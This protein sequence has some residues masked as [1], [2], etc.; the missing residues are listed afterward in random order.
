MQDR[1]RRYALLDL[2]FSKVTRDNR[3]AKNYTHSAENLTI[4]H[5]G[6]HVLNCTCRNESMNMGE[7]EGQ[8]VVESLGRGGFCS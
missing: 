1:G 2:T 7:G 6:E 5:W 8:E 3:L 4:G